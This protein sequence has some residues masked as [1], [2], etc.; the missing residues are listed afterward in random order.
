MIRAAL[1][2]L[3]VAVAALVAWWEHSPTPPQTPQ[4]DAPLTRPLHEMFAGPTF[5]MSDHRGAAVF[6]ML[7]TLDEYLGRRIVEG[8]GSHIATFYC[9]EATFVPVFRAGLRRLMREQGLADDV[10]ETTEQECLRAFDSEAV[11]ARINRAYQD[12]RRTGGRVNVPAGYRSQ[13]V[14]ALHVSDAMFEA[15]SDA[16]R[17]A[18]LAGAYARFGA[19]STFQFSNAEHKAAVIA[20]LLMQVGATDV[21]H[22]TSR[23]T[24]P[25]G[26]TVTFRALPA[27]MTALRRRPE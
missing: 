27:L 18:Y 14:I 17:T 20:R 2:V 1:A 25:N 8:R 22:H 12:R 13:E 24:I 7:G 19:D 16:D 10:A 4:A 9:N 6:W 21:R 23:D 11:G 5:D 26:N 3:V 15:R